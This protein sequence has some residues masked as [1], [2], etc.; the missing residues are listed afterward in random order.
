MTIRLELKQ[1]KTIII[2]I[3]YGKQE[4]KTTKQKAKRALDYLSW[5]ILK[6]S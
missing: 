6:Y 4:T 5:H 1:N 3:Y 2:W